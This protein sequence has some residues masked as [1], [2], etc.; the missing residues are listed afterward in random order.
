ME[1]NIAT[2]VIQTPTASYTLPANQINI[3]DVS[4]KFGT[5]LSSPTSL[6]A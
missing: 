1:N 4:D 3:S 2:L 6:S 5:T